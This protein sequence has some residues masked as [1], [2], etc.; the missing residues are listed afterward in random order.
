MVS[1]A[2]AGAPVFDMHRTIS[3]QFGGFCLFDG[4]IGFEHTRIDGTYRE[5]GNW[6][7]ISCVLT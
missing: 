2:K 6:C 3:F 1:L 4:P 7:M 5:T